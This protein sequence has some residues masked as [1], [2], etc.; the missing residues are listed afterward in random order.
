M[1]LKRC[2]ENL[3]T[4]AVSYAGSARLRVRC[5]KD[6]AACIEVLDEGPGIPADRLERVFEPYYRLEGSR[7]RA[8]G[9]IGLGLTI[10]RNL[11]ALTGA[12]L[13]LSNRAGGGLKAA[14]VLSPDRLRDG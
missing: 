2:I 1:C 7:N 4:N 11:A 12:T 8:F 10:A 9:G 5:G 14:I 6:G 3:V 13:M